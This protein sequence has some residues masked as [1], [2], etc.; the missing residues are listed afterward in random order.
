MSVC[1]AKWES[2]VPGLDTEDWEDD[3]FAH[4]TRLISARNQLIHYKFLHHIYMTP[5]KIAIIFGSVTSSCWGC[6]ERGAD[7]MHIFWDCP[8]IQKYWMDILMCVQKVTTISLSTSVRLCLL[9]LVDDLT[10]TAMQT[11]L[12]LLFFHDRKHI[13]LSWKSSTPPLVESWKVS[14]NRALPFYKATYLNRGVLLKFDKVWGGWMASP[15]TIT[16]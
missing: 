16:D 7:C 2:V 3:C 6:S 8:G 11:L 4:F 12:T 5:A 13:V 15:L 14:V 1:R 10:P 9:G